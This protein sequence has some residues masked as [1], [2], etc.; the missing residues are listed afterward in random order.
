MKPLNAKE[1]GCNPISSNCVIWQG[2]DIPCMSLCKGDT[3]SDVTYK[4]ATELCKIMDVLKVDAYDLSCFNLTSCKPADFQE[5]FQFIIERL[6]HVEQCSGCAP[7]CGTNPTPTPTPT[8]GGCPDCMMNIAECFYFTNGLGDEV[9]SLQMQDYVTALGNKICAIIQATGLNSTAIG[10]Q[11]ARISNVETQVTQIQENPPVQFQNMNVSCILPVTPNGYPLDVIVLQLESQFCQLRAATGDVSTIQADIAKQCAGLNDAPRLAGSG[12]MSSI[13]GWTTTVSNMADSLGNL[14]LTICDIRASILNLQ[15]NQPSGC[16]S[17]VLNLAANISGGNLVLFVTGTVPAGFAQ[18]TGST[19][20]AITDS[21]GGAATVTIDLLTILNQPGGFSMPLPGTINPA[22]N[23]TVAIP[24]CLND[25][26]NS[27][28]CSGYLSTVINNT[29]TCPPL[30]V[31]ANADETKLDY[32]FI[33]LNGSYT[34]TIQLYDEAGLTMIASQTQSAAVISPIAGTFT[35]LTACTNYK[36]RISIIPTGCGTCTPTICTFVDGSTGL[37][38]TCT[39]PDSV[40]AS[41][42]FV[43]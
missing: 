6:C 32:S 5:L 11:S 26:L 39:P 36:V 37:P 23:I 40:T 20:L 35:G 27:T 9:H 31:D 1:T 4:L 22:A 19:P 7:G 10:N 14:W 8:P 41:N 18:C 17:I 21:F 13:P 24:Y 28:S 38:T 43:P 15:A 30:S 3:V 2:P 25:V 29:I 42:V 34:Y 16:S 12:T 33:S